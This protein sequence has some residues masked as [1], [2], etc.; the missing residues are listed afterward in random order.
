[1]NETDA[2]GFPRFDPLLVAR[3]HAWTR[4]VGWFT[5]VL[6]AATFVYWIVGSQWLRIGT[7][8]IN[9]MRAN[10]A[11]GFLLGGLALVLQVPSRSGW[12]RGIARLCA[13]AVFLIGVP[14]LLE[15][16]RVWHGSVDL[17][18][19]A[20]DIWPLPG[21]HLGHVSLSSALGFVLLGAALLLIDS[22]V[23]RVYPSQW[24]A[25][26]ALFMAVLPA[27]GHVFGATADIGI[28]RGFQ[29]GL[30]SVPIFLVLASGGL[31]ARA[32]RGPMQ[33]AAR[34][35][36]AG[37]LLR[38]MLPVVVLLPVAVGSLRLIGEQAGLYETR[39]GI[40]I[41]AWSNA[42]ILCAII[43][44]YATVLAGEEDHR[45]IAQGRAQSTLNALQSPICV[46][47]K[48]G[49]IVACNRAWSETGAAAGA[50][51]AAVGIGANYLDVCDRVI[52]PEGESAR[53]V[54]SGMRAVLT[55]RSDEFVLEYTCQA[56]LAQSWWRVR[57]TRY[58]V[59][60]EQ[61]LVVAHEDIT[62]YR[63]QEQKILRLNRVY[64]VLS[65]INGVIVRARERQQ[66]FDEACRIAVEHGGFG[67]VWIDVLDASAQEFSPRAQAGADS[68][69]LLDNGRAMHLD[70]S[71]ERGLI[72]RA[73]ATGEH[74]YCND[75]A[76]ANGIDTPRLRSAVAL[77]Y[78]SAI[79]LPLLQEGAVVATLTLLN[80]EADYFDEAELRLLDELAADISLAL[81]HIAKREYIEHVAFH[82]TLTGLPNTRLFTDR[83]QQRM[84]NAGNGELAVALFD[85]E[86]FTWITETH[87]RAC[88][89]R[90]LR[91]IASRLSAAV[92]AECTV[93]RVGA[94]TFAI[95]GVCEGE[96]A[97]AAAC[98]QLLAR[99]SEPLAMNDKEIRISAH[100]GIAIFPRDAQDAETLFERAEA[101]LRQ[102]K[103]TRQRCLYFAPEVNAQV[104]E[105][106]LLEADLRLGLERG[107][108]TVVYQPKIDLTSGEVI[109]AEALLR[110]H[111]PQRGLM[112]PADFIGIAESTGLIVGLGDWVLHAVCEQQAA[113]L[114][115]G[116]QVV[117][118]MIN[119]SPVQI[120]EGDMLDRVQRALTAHA[121]ETR[122]IEL[123]LTE[124]AALHDSPATRATFAA[125]RK[126]GVCL[127]LDDFGTGYA[128]LEQIRRFPID[129]V[130]IDRAFVANI[131]A[132]AENGAI[133]SAIIAMSH[134]LQLRVVAEGV[135]TDAQLAFLR[136]H[137]CDEMQG[138]YFSPPLDP[139]ALEAMLRNGVRADL[140]VSAPE[141]RATVLVVD[142]EMGVRS[143]LHRVLR[144]DGYRILTAASGEAGLKLLATQRVQLVISDQRMPGMSGAE[145]LDAVNRHY[146]ET[147]RIVLS[148]Y[149][150]L[151]TVTEAVNRGAVFK[152]FTKPWNDDELREGVRQAIRLSRPAP[153]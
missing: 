40:A 26:A 109:G 124:T 28:E 75:L 12:V 148:G 114:A 127:S 55:H 77:G 120:A 88:G 128:S 97:S 10:A 66:L 17:L 78:R 125:L 133:V 82:D 7:P 71:D 143:A 16:A 139:A 34:R 73:F 68:A 137:D 138:F 69:I 101:A 119:V 43:Y 48:N 18:L 98:T 79:V 136:R 44:W 13:A 70:R 112:A 94:D 51:A 117:P 62:T 33:L 107:E 150:D 64:A 35:V 60:N 4:L 140:P 14:T 115:A 15:Y 87:G 2:I 105:R 104:A 80:R 86:N 8:A 67:V 3:Y 134:A 132:S 59:D 130:K 100:A 131:P 129:Y 151:A 65:G 122:H 83:L 37:R 147:V 145:F 135:E 38:R 52:G 99:I 89:D 85:L 91:E 31:V 45:R 61:W 23:R 121:L 111:H 39:F 153:V 53:A 50:S 63:V 21:W 103:T 113:W 106:L 92:P 123:E 93:A 96:A 144:R 142:D 24:L 9:A 141:Q 118:V 152:F 90:L 116:V 41:S 36:P 58:A 149:T 74:A 11:L 32:D 126:L 25:A 102:A 108:F 1:M 22:P 6:G 57:V 72:A 30:H 20:D 49:M 27:L 19:I 47:D 46:V 56:A 5:F 95:G 54:A 146:P 81:E 76:S 84:N 110:W 29:I 42:L